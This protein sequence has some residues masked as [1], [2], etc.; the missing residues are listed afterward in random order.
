M[1]RPPEHIPQ[2]RTSVHWRR[3][4][5]NDKRYTYGRVKQN[6]KRLVKVCYFA[7]EEN[8]RAIG[9]E[10]EFLVTFDYDPR[11]RLRAWVGIGQL[12][13]LPYFIRERL[14]AGGIDLVQTR[15]KRFPLYRITVALWKLSVLDSDTDVH[16]ENNNCLDDR[17]LN[18][19]PLHRLQHAQ[20]HISVRREKTNKVNSAGGFKGFFDFRRLKEFQE[21]LSQDIKTENTR[22]KELGLPAISR[23]AHADRAARQQ[24]MLALHHECR[25]ELGIK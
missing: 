10:I 25:Q 23:S 21:E 1:A 11:E 5:L 22:R 12:R 20:H 7:G 9:T 18:L 3:T 16:H 4:H 14:A 24:I 17:A 15:R 2:V 13:A 19:T 6:E 8:G